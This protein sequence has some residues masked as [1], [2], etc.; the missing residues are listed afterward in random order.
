MVVDFAGTVGPQKAQDL[1]L[2]DG[3]AD[4]VHSALAAVLLH[5]V[6]DF[7]HLDNRAFPGRAVAHPAVLIEWFAALPPPGRLVSARLCQRTGRREMAP[8]RTEYTFS[9][10][11]NCPHSAMNLPLFL[12]EKWVKPAALCANIFYKREKGCIFLAAQGQTF[13]VSQR[14][15]PP[16]CTCLPIKWAKR[17]RGDT[18][19]PDSTSGIN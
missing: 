13:P 12:C 16:I 14:S 2:V 5:E 8:R 11:T 3:E 10:Y 15:A 19:R 17:G 6:F 9:L 1:P 7:Y 4:V 18:L